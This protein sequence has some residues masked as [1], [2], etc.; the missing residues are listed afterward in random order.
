MAEGLQAKDFGFSEPLG[1]AISIVS[2]C[3]KFH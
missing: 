1:Q 3:I 2:L